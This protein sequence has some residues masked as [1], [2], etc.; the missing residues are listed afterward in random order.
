MQGNLSLI[1]AGTAKSFEDLK[2]G[3][4]FR[5]VGDGKVDKEI[6][7]CFASPGFVEGLDDRRLRA[8]VKTQAAIGAEGLPEEQSRERLAASAKDLFGSQW[9]VASYY[10]RGG[11]G[12]ARVDL[13]MQEP[14]VGKQTLYIDNRD[15]ELTLT[16]TV[17]REG[18]TIKHDIAGKQGTDSWMESASF[19]H[20]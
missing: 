6:A 16:S 5:V 20:S 2:T 18:W 11:S 17:R 9:N 13:E 19:E 12:V 15:N 3:F 8:F 14:G 1:G 4:K 7:D 10:S